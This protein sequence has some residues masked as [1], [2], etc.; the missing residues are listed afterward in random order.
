MYKRQVVGENS[1]NEDID[2][3]ICRE[4]AKTNI[5]T[6]SSDDTIRLTPPKVFSLE[7]ALESI[8]DDE[9]VEVTP[10]TIRIRKTVLDAGERARILKKQKH[11][12]D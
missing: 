10:E 9:C 2:V 4:K 12:R 7:Q 3:N 6:Q 1:R 8:A 5:R 11:P